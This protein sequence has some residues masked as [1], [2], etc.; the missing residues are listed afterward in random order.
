MGVQRRHITTAVTMLLLIGILVLGL[1]VGYQSL[2]KPLDSDEPTSTCTTQ[3]TGQRIRAKEVQV[4]VYNS[5]T[6]SGLASQTLRSLHR[7]GF[8]EG[9][10]G[11]APDGAKVDDVQ[12]WT[13]QKSDRAAKLVALQFGKDAKVVVKEE[14]IGP[15]IDVLVGNDYNGLKKAR[16]AIKV[17]K[18]AVD[19][20]VTKEKA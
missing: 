6:R 20:C 1:V 16:K 3:E 9:E 11:N 13:T 2:F 5:G 15:G 8:R 10:V 4:S 7:R 17:K 12:V 14:S 18:D 19:V